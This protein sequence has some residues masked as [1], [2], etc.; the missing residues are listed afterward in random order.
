MYPIYFLIISLLIGAFQI[1]IWKTP[2]IEA[3][4][5]GML[6]GNVGLQAL[7]AFL[8]HFFKSDEVAKGI[9]WPAGNPF[10][11]EIAFTNLGYG[12]LGIMCIWFRDGFWLATIIGKSIFLWG[13]GY[14]HVAEMK[15][16]KNKNIF[17]AGPILYFDILFPFI[18][19]GMYILLKVLKI[20]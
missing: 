14:I 8:G 1:I 12:I 10:Q 2:P 18:L 17:N 11:K 7:Y 20:K 13:A 5:L 4:L 16:K 19:I 6:I 9:G 15:K 3:F